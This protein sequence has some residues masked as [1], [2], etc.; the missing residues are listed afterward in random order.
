MSASPSQA[1]SGLYQLSLPIILPEQPLTHCPFHFL[2]ER[3]SS[4][5]KVL[6]SWEVISVAQCAFAK[7]WMRFY[8]TSAH[9]FVHSH[10]I[11]RMVCRQMNNASEASSSFSNLPCPFCS[12]QYVLVQ[13]FIDHV[14]AFHHKVTR[15]SCP[16]SRCRSKFY[17]WFDLH[18]HII[19]SH[20]ES[21]DQSFLSQ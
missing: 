21:N 20:P 5:E 18:M 19:T 14:R 6:V 9:S 17:F 15:L 13:A 3:G 1:Y 7:L 11:S 8:S 10:S 4:P 12:R 2:F 16:N